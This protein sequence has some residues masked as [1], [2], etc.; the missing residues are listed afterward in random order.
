MRLS[1]LFLAAAGLMLGACTTDSGGGGAL[2]SLGAE[3]PLIPNQVS[4]GD[5]D[6]MARDAAARQQAELDAMTPEEVRAAR[7]QRKREADALWARAQSTGNTEEAID[8]YDQLGDDYPESPNAAEARYREAVYLWRQRE[9]LDAFDEFERYMSNAPINPHL[10]QIERMVFYAGVTLLDR[11]ASLFR[12]DEPALEMLRFVA[13][14]FPRGSYADDALYRL[15]RYYQ[16]QREWDI[17]VLSY[18][19]LLINHPRSEWIY[20]TRLAMGDT[21]LQRDQ[22]RNYHAGFV[23]RDPRQELPAEEAAAFA[24]PVRSGLELALEQFEVFLERIEAD[25]TRRAEYGQHI[26][27]ARG[28]CQQIRGALAEKERRTAQWYQ[29]QGDP[30]AA[31]LYNRAAQ[32]WL[33][34]TRGT[35]RSAGGTVRVT[36]PAPTPVVPVIPGPAAPVAPPTPSGTSWPVMPVPQPDPPSIP[37]DNVTAPVP[38]APT[39]PN[40]PYAVPGTGR[41][42]PPP[43][44]PP[45]SR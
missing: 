24:G 15:G 29:Q 2:N 23:D 38:P 31:A 16:G 44:P 20:M 26:Q 9:Y 28:R 30:R 39:G 37:T 4:G 11:G 40:L 7:A 22:G 25:P 33:D 12:S 43:P 41:V 36:R 19:E 27:Y 14:N 6:R 42:P 17:A 1:L 8:L 13:Q 18:K 5:R 10:K 45:L 21:Y 3:T 35:G 34:G 32:S